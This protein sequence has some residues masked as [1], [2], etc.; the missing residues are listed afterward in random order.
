MKTKTLAM[1]KPDA[2]SSGLTGKVIELIELNGFTIVNV[3]K[4]ILT[5]SEV[6]ELY[7]AH[8]HKLWFNDYI[9]KLISGPVILMILEKEDSV[10]SWRTLMGATNPKNAEMG[11]IRRMWGKSIDENITH[12]SDSN[13]NA[14]KEIDFFFF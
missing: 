11:T 1:I 2:V 9:R 13:E 14:K 10:V 4:K 7:A 12:G 5:E 3:V 6:K 8:S